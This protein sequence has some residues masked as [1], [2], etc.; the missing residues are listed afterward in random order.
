MNLIIETRSSHPSSAQVETLVEFMERN[1]GMAKGFLRT[2]SA[3]ERSRR[4]WEE[5][6][7]RLNSMGGTI[8][9]YKQWTKYW[10]DKKSAIK[11]KVAARAAAR[12]RTDGGLED[13][14][15]ELS[16]VEE[17]IVALCCGENLSTGDAHL[18]IQPLPPSPNEPRPEG[19]NQ[20]SHQDVPSPDPQ[21][22]NTEDVT[23]SE[24]LSPASEILQDEDS[25]PPEPEVENEIKLFCPKCKSEVS[26]TTE[27]IQIV[28]PSPSRDITVK[29]EPPSPQQ[30]LEARSPPA[31]HTT[32][33][34]AASSARKRHLTASRRRLIQRTPPSPLARLTERFIALEEKRLDNERLAIQNQKKMLDIFQAM[35]EAWTR[36]A[37]AM[38]DLCASIRRGT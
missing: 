11:K 29:D 24:P 36:Q 31:P 13:E 26:L 23:E 2:Q 34:P 7:L 16:E 10:S 12:H 8:K 25:L 4:K 27:G 6:A 15:L 22:M 33:V 19:V 14:L 18:G 35:S 17:R 21:L 32:Y 20:D 28:Q 5:L 37:Q 30:T 1:P 3:R 38:Q 9:T